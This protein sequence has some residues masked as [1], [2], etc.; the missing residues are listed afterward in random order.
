MTIFFLFYFPII[1]RQIR[2]IIC[3]QNFETLPAFLLYRYDVIIIL[4]VL[5]RSM[6][7]TKLRMVK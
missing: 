5:I 1:L 2:I 4:H 6:D 7:V 3:L